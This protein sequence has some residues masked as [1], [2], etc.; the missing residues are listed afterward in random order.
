[1]QR[2]PDVRKWQVLMLFKGSRGIIHYLEEHFYFLMTSTKKLEF[3]L[4]IPHLKG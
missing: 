2:Q 3:F 4:G 1:M